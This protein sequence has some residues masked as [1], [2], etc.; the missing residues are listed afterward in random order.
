MLA[1]DENRAR[2]SSRDSF[3]D[4]A[5]QGSAQPGAPDCADDNQIGLPF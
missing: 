1:D 4:T 5:Q 3:G 2:R